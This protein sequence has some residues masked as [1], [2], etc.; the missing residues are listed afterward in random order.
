MPQ[1]RLMLLWHMHQPYYKD[2]VENRYTMPWVRLHALKDYYGMVA[3]LKAFPDVHVTF[4]VVP[5]LADQILDYASGEAHEESYEIAF[6]P[7]SDLSRPEKQALVHYAFQL[8]HE[9]L[10]GR[11]PRFVELFQRAKGDGNQPV[12]G[13]ISGTQEI[14]DLQVLSQLA[15]FDEIYLELDHQVRR[16][17]EKQ[18]NYT[19]EDKRLL[20]DKETELLKAVLEEYRA[21]AE[22][23]RIEISTSPFYHPIL[24]LL[25]DTDAGAESCPGLKLPRHRFFH[26]EDARDQ[27]RAAIDLHQRVFGHRVRGLWPSEGSVSETV[28]D[29]AAEEGF[30]WTATDEGVLGRSLRICFNRRGDGS[31]ENARALYRPYRTTG[32]KPLAI[33]FR[34]HPLSDLVG[35]V[36][37]RMDPEAAANDL[38]SRIRGGARNAGDEPVVSIILDGENAWE[39]YSGNG[40]VFLTHFY[41]QLSS[42]PDVRAMTPSEILAEYRPAELPAVVPGSWINANFNV[43]IGADEDNRAWD[44]LTSARDFFAERCE[45]PS[46]SPE[47]LATARQELW[48][49]EGSDWCWWYGPEHSTANDEH[50]D[51]LYRL[52]LSNMYQLLGGRVP[53]DLASPVKRLIESGQN[54]PPSALIHPTIDGRETTYFEWMGAGIYIPDVRSAAIHDSSRHV[55]QLFYGQGEDSL[56]LRLDLKNSFLSKNG[57]FTIRVNLRSKAAWYIQS[58][59]AGGVLTGTEVWNDDTAFHPKPGRLAGI[60]AEFGNFF[61]LGTELSALGLNRIDEALLQVSVWVNHLPVQILPGEGWLKISLAGDLVVW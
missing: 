47:R 56:W 53:D 20:Q 19:E 3:A 15:W 57:Q 49:A 41:N 8:N 9:N 50:F 52:H 35:F 7:A 10:M 17:A 59:I 37:H 34:D 38:I 4:N 42:S 55:E 36:Y 48:I 1:I 45:H 32:S 33:F 43:W 61:E 46:I 16:L 25:C 30:E 18:R 14:L 13:P 2:L 24:P 28:L 27:L 39:Y 40:R 6:K 21:A 12:A 5:S 58:F 44:L 22:R 31:V 51:R 23:G 60:R 26:P 29:L 11:F 54:V